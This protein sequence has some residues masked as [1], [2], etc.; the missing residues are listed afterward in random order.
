MILY[1]LY[2]DTNLINGLIYFNDTIYHILCRKEQFVR[3]ENGKKKAKK[4]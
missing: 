3:V 1:V 2:K 4:I